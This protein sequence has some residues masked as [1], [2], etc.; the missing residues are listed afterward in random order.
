MSP[1]GLQATSLGTSLDPK[2]FADAPLEIRQLRIS[3]CWQLTTAI[4]VA[5]QYAAHRIELFSERS[6]QDTG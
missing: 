3:I 5:R 1:I 6:Q 2:E 4:E